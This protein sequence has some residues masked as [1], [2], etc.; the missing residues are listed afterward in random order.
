MKIIAR[1]SSVLALCAFL[2]VSCSQAPKDPMELTLRAEIEHLTEAGAKV[3]L[4]SFELVDSTSLGEEIDYRIKVFNIKLD[5]DRKFRE[6]YKKEGRPVNEAKK[7]EAIAN[8]ER[9]IAGLEAMKIA[10]ADSLGTI[11]FRDYRFSGKAVSS[12]NET[13][14]EDYY[15]A[16]SPEG[17]VLA[18][19]PSQKGL[20]K[21]LGRVIPGYT[22]LIKGV[23]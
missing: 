5:Q 12:E 22:E 4:N 18:L 20:H 13:V 14:F 17:E 23:E 15:A 8:D 2:S 6:Q 11:V 10:M 1:L 16:I 9:V 21:S 7:V 19:E 3:L